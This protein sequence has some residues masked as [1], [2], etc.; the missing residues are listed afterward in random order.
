[1]EEV[2]RIQGEHGAGND[3][4]VGWLCS[5]SVVDTRTMFSLGQ[6][7]HA[8]FGGIPTTRI[9]SVVGKKNPGR[10]S[11]SEPGVVMSPPPFDSPPHNLY[12]ALRS[13]QIFHWH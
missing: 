12:H 8:G 3:F 1:M 7:V 10:R 2:C 4:V 13:V 6:A 11:T 5:L 9:S